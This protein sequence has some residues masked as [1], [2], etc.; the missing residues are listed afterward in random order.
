MSTFTFNNI[1]SSDIGLMVTKTPIPPCSIES[2]E[3]I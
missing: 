2:V 1:L 3:T